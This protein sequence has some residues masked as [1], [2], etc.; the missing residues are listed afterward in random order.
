MTEI[1]QKIADLKAVPFDP[2]GRYR[3][4]SSYLAKYHCDVVCEIGIRQGFHFKYII[5]HNPKEAVA[6]DCWIE[7]G[8]VGINDSC[9]DQAG[10]E[11]QY[12]KFKG[13]MTD[14]PFVK[15]VRKYSFDAVK[16]FPDEYFDYIFIDANHTYEG[17][18]RDLVD[19][20]PKVKKGGVLCGH[21]YR[22]RKSR[23][24]IGRIYKF[25]VV[26]AVDEF[27]KKNNITDFFVLTPNPSWVIIK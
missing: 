2:S 13:L 6:I 8:V 16:D 20:Y 25:G 14:K 18:S 7:D 26:E 23:D 12:E 3:A 17:V 15:I 4:W 27:V 11:R 5:E 21:D 19:W 24:A 1:E 9:Y 10:L 22:G